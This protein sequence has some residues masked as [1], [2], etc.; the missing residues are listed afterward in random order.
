MSMTNPQARLDY[1]RAMPLNELLRYRDN[2]QR[3]VTAKIPLTA[4]QRRVLDVVVEHIGISDGKGYSKGV[5]KLT[6]AAIAEHAGIKGNRVDERVRRHLKPLL[7]AEALLV[8][9]EGRGGSGRRKRARHM[10]MGELNFS[11]P[12]KTKSQPPQTAGQKANLNPHKPAESQPP[13]NECQPPQTA[14]QAMKTANSR[15]AD[16]QPPQENTGQPPQKLASQ[17]PQNECQPPQNCGDSLDQRSG[18]DKVT[19]CL[20]TSARAREAWEESCLGLAGEPVDVDG[21]LGA[22][23]YSFDDL[24]RM[25]RE[26]FTTMGEGPL[27][28]V[29][30]E[31]GP[32]CDVNWGKQVY[33]IDVL[34]R[35]IASLPSGARSDDWAEDFGRWIDG[36]PGGL[37]RRA[38]LAA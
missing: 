11:T 7:D 17:P 27:W 32:L 16:S 2:W 22:G 23:R 13:Q 1:Y 34:N 38:A 3:A 6:N 37:R 18:R 29:V 12:T 19:S 24:V 21:V 5:C 31:R 20:T 25:R 8:T 35:F 9:Q 15:P 36:E 10:T 4:Q 30:A 28:D 14:G 33:F 26:H